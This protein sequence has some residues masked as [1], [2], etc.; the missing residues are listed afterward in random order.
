MPASDG[1]IRYLGIEQGLSNNSVRS[2]LQ[3]RNGYL[4]FGTYNGLCRYDGYSFRL[5]YNEPGDSLS[6]PNNHVYALY[7]DRQQ[8]LWAG[9]D[10]GLGVYH[11][12][13]GRFRPVYF[14]PAGRQRPEKIGMQVL[15]L[16]A[17]TSGNLFIGTNGAGLLVRYRGKEV[18]EQLPVLVHG[19]L[20]SSYFFRSLK[21]DRRQRV[22]LVVSQLGLCV[23][24]PGSRQ[25]RL[26]SSALTEAWDLETDGQETVWIGTRNGLYTYRIATNTLQPA[27]PRSA[28]VPASDNV[29]SL[30]LDRQ[31]QLWMG[32]AGEG[33]FVQDTRTG[34]L[35]HLE[36][37]LP[38]QQPGRETFT[39]IFEDKEGRKWFGTLKG[40]LRILDPFPSPFR[41]IAHNPH[42]ANSL[43][44]NFV[45]AFLEDRQGR[46]WI[47]TDGG[48]L[49]I[50]NRP[51]QTFSNYQHQEGIPGSLG[52][53]LVVG[54]CQDYLGAVWVT[55]FGGDV[56]RFNETTRSF[57]SF[58]CINPA[59]GEADKNVRLLY[60]DREKNLW[61]NTYWPGRLYRFN[62]ALHRFELY[63]RQTDLSNLL[64]L[65]G[66]RSGT[67]WAGNSHAL[68]RIDSAYRHTHYEIGTAV[69]DIYE[70]KKGN[71]WVG[72][73]G[74]GLLRFDRRHGKIDRQYTTANGLCNNS[75]LRILE[76]GIGDLWLSTFYGLSLFDPASGTFKNFYQE[77]G[78]QSN[79]FSY[80]AALRLRSGEL[81]FGGIRGFNLFQPD[82]LRLN[83]SQAPLL[84]T[85]L[86]YNNQPVWAG[87]RLVARVRGDQVA[88]LRLPAG[89]AVLSVDFAAL[90]FASPQRVRYTYRLEGHQQEWTDPGRERTAHFSNLAPGQYVLRIRATLPNGSW[91]PEEIRLPVEVVPPWYRSWW[92]NALY[93]LLAG[94]VLLL[95][96]GYRASRLRLQYQ[97]KVARLHTAAEQAERGRQEAELAR[98]KAERETEKVRYEKEEEIREKQFSFFTQISQEF[99]TPLTLIANP[100]KALLEQDPE[101]RCDRERAELTTVYRNARRMLS[102]VEQLQLFRK[103][104]TGLDRLAAAPLDLCQL[105]R[106]VY[107][108]FVQQAQARNIDYQFD[109]SEQPLE[110]YA[111]AAKLE[112]ILYNLLSNALHFTPQGGSVSLRITGQEREVVLEI[113]DSGP[114][115]PPEVGDRLFEKYLH[116]PEGVARAPLGLGIGLYLVRHFTEQHKG[117]VSCRSGEGTGTTITLRLLRG[118][119]HF[120]PGTVREPG[121]MAPGLLEELAFEEGDLEE[122]PAAGAAPLEEVVD[123]VIT[124]KPTLLVVN[125]DPE[126]RKYLLR[127]LQDRYLLYEAAGGEEGLVVARK[128]LPDLVLT[129]VQLEGN[130]GIDLCKS[131]KADP[132]LQHIPVILLTADSA[133][134][135][136]LKGVEG[137]AD[138]YVAKPFDRDFLLARIASLLKARTSL[139]QYFLNEVTMSRTDQKIPEEYREFLE[140]CIETVER[141]LDD[142]E[143][144]VKTLM[145]EMGMS[146]SALYKKVKS[147]SGQSVSSFIRFIRL[148]KAAELLI[149]TG[150][151]ISEAARSVGFL[152]MK[153]FRKQFCKLFGMNPSDYI[154]KYRRVFSDKYTVKK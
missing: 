18:A 98:E 138:A 150:M 107:L 149:T 68:I 88:A 108:C 4:W 78:L 10:K 42:Q 26:V 29:L 103:A 140:Q 147:V 112:I 6:L 100:V 151:N 7:E 49:S 8:N 60:E 153:Y 120:D 143:F 22:W 125:D 93:I 83:N 94:V 1:G 21:V 99:R 145:T 90:N 61:A 56:S 86:R 27:F 131:L 43:V 132:A 16:D 91:N 32:T 19:K 101:Q 97:V 64:T 134:E 2:I 34:A 57:E 116:A 127:L 81:A 28:G 104:E 113:Q 53:N 106:E 50:W 5:F 124:D 65:A 9:T 41:T 119:A 35:R 54:L 30:C 115:V 40:G 92:A 133:P 82:S 76:N 85:G 123:S 121:A 51:A 36:P 45:S 137:G 17:D 117:S 114:G 66:D 148:R 14:I 139:Q 95:Y 146:H 15:V 55:T 89:E 77:D 69:R 74:G 47:G 70:D 25:L 84:I 52:S 67:L 58:P 96:L 111:D 23:Y 118:T 39:C 12:L 80:G 75:V 129:E 102:L 87:N 109:C 13:S 105:S 59:T 128:Q 79:Q 154:A 141:H 46:L 130:R 152:E 20:T 136:L 37:A 135:T 73:E 110:I 63:N 62:R 3:D 122:V 31:H 44:H 33:I 71:L 144:S 38:G 126:M 11:N 72:T 24:E 142:E 48:G